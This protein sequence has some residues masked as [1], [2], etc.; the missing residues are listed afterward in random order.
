MWVSVRETDRQTETER[1]ASAGRVG[2]V[3]GL[4]G[5]P[6]WCDAAS[7]VIEAMMVQLRPPVIMDRPLLGCTGPVGSHWVMP[8]WRQA[9]TG[10]VGA[11]S[12]SGPS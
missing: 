4:W 9:A 7:T 6:G 11:G 5:A 1:E 12:W 10:Q 2:S 3:I 8:M